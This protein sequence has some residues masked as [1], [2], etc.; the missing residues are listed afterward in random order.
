LRFL[1]LPFLLVLSLWPR[2]ASPEVAAFAPGEL[3]VKFALTPAKLSPKASAEL[4]SLGRA[5]GVRSQRPLFPV[6]G[7]P[8]GASKPAPGCD[9]G[10]VYLLRLADWADPEEAASAYSAEPLVEYAQPNYLRRLVGEPDDPH[11]KDQWALGVIG[12]RGIWESALGFDEVIVAIIDSGIDYEHSDLSSRIWH[13]SAELNGI[14]GVD[15]DGNGYVDDVIGWDFTDAPGFLGLGDYLVRDGDPMDESGHGTHVAGIVAATPDNGLGIAGVAPNARLMVLRAGFR[16]PEGGFLEDDDIAAAMVYAADNGARVINMSWG[17]PRPSPLMRDAVRYAYDRG[18]VLVAA[19][20]NEG[21]PSLYYPAAFDETIAVGASD[22]FD[23]VLRIS[24]YGANID[25]VAPGSGVISTSIGGGYEYWS[26]T[27]MAAPHV[28]GLA[29][30]VLGLC[31]DAT[32]EQVRTLLRLSAEDI[33][34]PGPDVRSGFGRID[35]GRALSLGPGTVARIVAPQAGSGADTAFTVVLDAIGPDIAGYR[36]EYGGGQDPGSWEAIAEGSGWAWG[37]TV[38]S[39]NVSALPESEY[40]LRLMIRDAEGVYREVDRAS[41][42]VDH[43]P[44]EFAGIR[45]SEKLDGERALTFIEWST[46]DPSS[47]YIFYRMEGSPLDPDSLY[48]PSQDSFHSVGLPDDIP[49]GRYEAFVRAKNAAGLLSESDTV[50]FDV[51]SELIPPE[52]FSELGSLPEG[53]F[54]P[55]PTDF[56]DDGRPELILMPLEGSSTYNE[57]RFYELEDGSFREVFSTSWKFLPWDAGDF[58]GDGKLELMGVLG[59]KLLLFEGRSPGAFPSEPVWEE[60]DSWG[61]RAFDMDGDGRLEIISVSGSSRD[62]LLFRNDGDN[63]FHRA[64]SFGDLPADGEARIS[65]SFL[66]GDFD[67]DGRGEL[68]GGSSDGDVFVYDYMAS[69][70][71]RL[72]WRH[73]LRG[74]ETRAIAGGVDLDMDGIAEFVVARSAGDVRNPERMFWNI[75]IYQAEGGAYRPEWQI[76]VLGAEERGNGVSVADLEGDGRPEIIAALLPDIYIFRSDGPDSYRPSWHSYVGLTYIPFAG[77]LNGDGLSEIAFNGEGAARVLSPELRPGRPPAPA[78]VVARP[79]GP[80]EI[81]VSWIAVPG[82][83][84]RIYRGE[85]PDSLRLLAGGLSSSPYVDSG[86]DL[87]KRYY[88][89]VSSF[90]S[91]ASP[92]E[93]GR[94]R[95]VSAATAFPPELLG[96]EAV[97]RFHVALSFNRPMGGSAGDPGNYFVSGGVGYPSSAILD[98]G[99]L[100][101]VLGF[102]RELPPGDGYVVTASGIRD[103]SGMAISPQGNA[104]SFS[105]P[106]RPPRCVLISAELASPTEVILSFTREL[107]PKS[108]TPSSFSIAPG[109]RIADASASGTNAVRLTLDPATPIVPMGFT[110]RVQADGARGKDGG[111]VTG[112]AYLRLS[113]RDLSGVFTF[114]NPFVTGGGRRL[115]FGGLPVSANIRIYSLEGRLIREI[116]ES[117]GDGGA[118]WDGLNGDGEPVGS[119]IYIYIVSSGGVSKF[120]KLAVVRR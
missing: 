41:V 57:V 36:V 85:D 79:L 22:S 24:N 5:F 99:G 55:F 14:E 47:G 45:A 37:D 72:S 35:V 26:G 107:D 111:E 4:D 38:A 114:P 46:D 1:P 103:I 80:S 88:Y 90:D 92:P 73:G 81:E 8:G 33:G 93:S 50:S 28:S 17:D 105:V 74:F 68:I 19:V 16:L 108:I 87:G 48:V 70:I 9:L 97:D 32:A 109:I 39:W 59:G 106:R 54:L 77:D 11:F 91:L 96:A 104:A 71:F 76:E 82:L 49:S 110:Y 95:V 60:P 98:R 112:T 113:A 53:Y 65:P 43:T 40:T 83:T 69:D 64:A 89:A 42:T 7:S 118:E 29:A 63:S 86:L 75:T 6:C 2:V 120:G 44:P 23:E 3:I 34:P 115:T 66:V 27:S 94:S 30:L 101:A 61:G 100:R 51:R 62:F 58:D 52:G 15:D 84:Y 102:D 117:D 119:G 21:S 18:C 25:L 67:G 78:G 20:G 12:W 10:R 56:D 116:S 31:P 13:N